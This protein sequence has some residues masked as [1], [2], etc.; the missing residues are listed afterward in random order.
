[1]ATT[2]PRVSSGDGIGSDQNSSVNAITVTGA[3]D[4]GWTRQN[5]EPFIGG[6][7]QGIVLTAAGAGTVNGGGVPN[8]SGLGLKVFIDITV[9]TGTGPTLTVFVQVQDPASGKWVTLL[10]SAALNAVATTTLTIFPGATVTANVSA[11]D[12]ITRAF[13]IGYTVA[14]T[15]PAVTAT[16][17]ATVLV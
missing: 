16:I 12:H 6:G 9:I 4:F 7:T 3:N 10:T 8:T 2:N 15:T 17:G 14:G 13:R 11:N 1:M 5:N